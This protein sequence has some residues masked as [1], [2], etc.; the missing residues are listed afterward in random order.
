MI[1]QRALFEEEIQNC[2]NIFVELWS[3]LRDKDY[4]IF[5]R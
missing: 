1:D 4:E 5:Q 2:S 3:L